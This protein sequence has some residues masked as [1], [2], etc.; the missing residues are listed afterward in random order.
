[1]FKLILFDIDGTLIRTGGAG[2][3]AF[4]KTFQEEY[5]LPHATE[6]LSFAGRTDRRLVELLFS[7]NDIG[8]TPSA[9]ERFF[10]VYLGHL[11]HF[12]PKDHTTPLEGV[13]E[14]INSMGKWQ[15]TPVIGLLTGNHPQ[16]AQLKLNHYNLWHEFK[17]GVFGDKHLDR[18]AVAEEAFRWAQ[19][20]WADIDPE[21]ILIIGDTLRDIQCA[22]SIGA[23]VLAVATGDSSVD[24]LK[25][26]NPDWV[27]SNLT[28]TALAD[29]HIKNGAVI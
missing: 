27:V 26:H 18:E 17:M 20:R 13:I 14:L 2:V 25:V 16:G 1:M 19:E 29:F 23:R 3:K 9:V 28:A 11:E 12:L 24:E 5:Q 4:G 8:I 10:E 15:P 6:S 21:Q 7:Q 22:R